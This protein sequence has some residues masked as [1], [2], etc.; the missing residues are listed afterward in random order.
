MPS[1]LSQQ[2]W[3]LSDVMCACDSTRLVNSVSD[4]GKSISYE[5]SFTFQILLLFYRVFF[6]VHEEQ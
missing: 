6:I 3:F 5:H 4:Q 2:D 1:L